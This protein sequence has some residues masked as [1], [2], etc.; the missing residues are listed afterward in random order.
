MIS[1]SQ[2]IEEL[3]RK[4]PFLEE[5]L[6][7]GFIN[8]SSLARKFRP[9]VE[10]RLMKGVTEGAI[11]MALK[12]LSGKLTK[13]QLNKN[14]LKELGDITIRSN[15]VDITFSNSPTLIKA[16]E[17]LLAK[18]TGKNG[19][20]LTIS[21][22]TKEVT[23]IASRNLVDDI[24]EIFKNEKRISS[25][26]NLSSITIKLAPQTSHIPGVYYTILKLLAWDGINVTEI[27]STYTELTIVLENK[28]I[29][30]AFSVLKNYT[31][32]NG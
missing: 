30:R 19:D 4:S 21:H 14:L 11:I 15:L 3:I 22:G 20:F 2:V 18:I 31:E 10:R 7:R 12:R 9:Q 6:T 17:K 24:K 32:E 16:Q 28:D 23:L 29:D 8:H 13:R 26:S 1:T 27:V 25:F 5:G